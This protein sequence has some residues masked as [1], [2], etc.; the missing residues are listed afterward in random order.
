MPDIFELKNIGFSYTKAHTALN[1]INLSVKEGEILSIIGSNGSGKSTLLHLMC[2]LAFPS[3]G[4]ISYKGKEFNE[5]SFKDL[6]FNRTFR[7]AIGYV[8]QDSDAQLFCPTVFDELIF[9]PLQLGL[10]KEQALERA[11]SI[12]QMLNI[13]G[14]RNRPPYMLSGGEKKRVA[15]GAILTTN[16]EILIFDEPMSGLDPKT[17]SFIIEMI[18]QLNQAG[19]T[20]IIATHHLE[21]VNHFQSRTVVLSEKHNIEKIGQSHEILT[22]NCLL[23]KANLIGEYPHFHDGVVHKHMSKAFLFHNHNHQQKQ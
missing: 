15:I 8:F 5:K 9:G 20:I 14:L 17:R 22:D 11:E 23:I 7:S 12:S 19:K 4:S 21:L 16:P 13:Q 1:D 3:C 10:S 18:F 2:G 6:S